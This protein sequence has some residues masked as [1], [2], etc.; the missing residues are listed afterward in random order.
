MSDGHEAIRRP[1]AAPVSMMVHGPWQIA[2]TGVP[3][4]KKALANAT[5]FG[6]VRSASGFMTPPGQEERVELLRLGLVEGDV[7]RELVSPVREV[8]SAD[9]LIPGRDDARFGA[10]LVERLA[11]LDHLDLLK[12][13]LD[14]DCDLQPLVVCHLPISSDGSASL[15]DFSFVHETPAPILSRLEGLD[16]RMLSFVEMLPCMPMRGGIAAADVTAGET[17][18]Q[19]HPA[20]ADS[21]AILAA[22]GTR[23][24]IAQRQLEKFAKACCRG[25]DSKRLIPTNVVMKTIRTRPQAS[26][27][28]F[29]R[30]ETGRNKSRLAL[31]KDFT[32]RAMDGGPVAKDLPGPPAAKPG[33]DSV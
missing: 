29:T 27:A 24:Y 21:Q 30:R 26:E 23:C 16:D 22:F 11:R 33:N 15:S 5:A 25:V 19:V 4:S 3:A 17:Q 13:V 28:R 9:V 6:S 31:A 10:G 20:R 12:S 18:A 1:R 14:Q 2:A 32:L 8:P 7:D